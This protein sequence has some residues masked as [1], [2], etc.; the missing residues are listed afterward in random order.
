MC[1]M[2]NLLTWYLCCCLNRK[3]ALL[4]P[5]RGSG[6]IMYEPDANDDIDDE[7]PDDDLDV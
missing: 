6:R 1:M 5:G 4:R 3:S 2:C 7:D